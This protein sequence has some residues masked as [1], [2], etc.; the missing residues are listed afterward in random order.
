MTLSVLELQ[1]KGRDDWVDITSQVQD[2][3]RAR[4]GEGVV[5]V[6][7]PHTTAGV[8]IQENADPPLKRD[9]TKMLDRLYPWNAD[10]GHCE[11]NAAAHMKAI[12]AGPSVQVPFSNGDLALGTWQGIYFCE[13]DGPRSR[14]VCVKLSG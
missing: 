8:V 14:R 10:Y 3:V 13:F 5:T 12:Y 9:I 2:L 11:D 7:V 4:G 6:F 1:S